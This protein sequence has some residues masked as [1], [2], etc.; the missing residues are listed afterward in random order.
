LLETSCIDDRLPFGN[1]CF[2]AALKDPKV[3]ERFAQRGTEPVS[4]ERATPAVLDQH[5]HAEIAKWKL[6]IQTAGVY[7]D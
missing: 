1:L 6:I 3:I 5:L 7:A 4:L 2:Q